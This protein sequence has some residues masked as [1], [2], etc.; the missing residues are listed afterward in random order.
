MNS[1]DDRRDDVEYFQ[2][3]SREKNLLKLKLSV[4]GDLKEQDIKR[5]RKSHTLRLPA[6]LAYSIMRELLCPLI[7]RISR[8]FS[9]LS[10]SSHIL[11]SFWS[12]SFTLNFVEKL[13]TQVVSGVVV[14][15][16]RSAGV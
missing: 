7:F 8:D 9:P 12:G 1:R 14:S 3:I 6:N 11:S 2:V 4:L 10:N 15:R 13:P 5:E 16:P